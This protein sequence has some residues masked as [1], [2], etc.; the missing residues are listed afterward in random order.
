ML[1]GQ[2]RDVNE[3]EIRDCL[4]RLRGEIAALEHRP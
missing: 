1:R 3:T 2:L 4:V